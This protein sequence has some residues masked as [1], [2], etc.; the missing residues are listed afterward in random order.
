MTQPLSVSTLRRAPEKA[1][2]AYLGMGNYKMQNKA[3]MGMR[4]SGTNLLI[5]ES[6]SVL[7]RG[8]AAHNVL[9]DVDAEEMG[10]LLGDAHT[11]ELGIAALHLDDC[12]NEFGGGTFFIACGDPRH[13]FARIYCDAC[14]H[15]FLLAY[16]CKTR[17][18]ARPQSRQKFLKRSGA[19]S[20]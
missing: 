13:G 12:H 6:G 5:I 14:R 8:H 20:V 2:Y 15:E 16:S 10:D 9:V 18:P 3:A 1:V 7:L 17:H 4:L 19:S 11:A